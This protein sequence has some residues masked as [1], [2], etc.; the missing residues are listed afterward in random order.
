MP[1]KRKVSEDGPPKKRAPRRKREEDR[2]SDPP[3]ARAA[4]AEP[5]IS[6]D[7]KR[8]LILAHAAM[9]PTRDPVQFMSMWAGVLVA[10]I[11]IVTGWWWSVGSG[12]A[13][14]WSRVAGGVS[15]DVRT[16]GQDRD[17]E[18]ANELMRVTERL[19]ALHDQAMAQQAALDAMGP[20]A[21]ST[22]VFAPV[23]TTTAPIV[24]SSTPVTT[25][26][27]E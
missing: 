11:A 17:S 18:V 13:S 16:L 21:S 26:E 2:A 19:Q 15:H 22:V 3:A 14:S 23:A 24:P 27:A 5:V 20:S 1:I 12:L 8:R 10:V 4:G 25:T 6:Q 9:R 7:E